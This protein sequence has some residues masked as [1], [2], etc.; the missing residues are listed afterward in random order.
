MLRKSPANVDERKKWLSQIR[1]GTLEMCMLGVLSGQARY[2]FEIAQHLLEAG[3]DVTEGTLYP[4]LNRLLAEGLIEASWRESASG[5]P[6]KYYALTAAG[7]ESFAWM[8]T[9]WH[10]YAAVIHRLLALP[11]S[12]PLE[13]GPSLKVSPRPDS[14]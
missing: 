2:G 11:P 7:Q 9:A 14:D 3:L 10:D 8:R 12:Q 4:L 1:K 13:G 6:R 5:P